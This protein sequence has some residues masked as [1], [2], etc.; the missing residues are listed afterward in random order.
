MKYILILLVPLMLMAC[1]GY[2]KEI[3]FEELGESSTYGNSDSISGDAATIQFTPYS[4][5]VGDAY[6]D[7]VAQIQTCGQRLGLG[8]ANI[9]AAAALLIPNT[10]SIISIAYQYLGGDLNL[11]DELF[12]ATSFD[13][14][15]SILAGVSLSCGGTCNQE[16]GDGVKTLAGEIASLGI[17][18][19]ELCL[20]S[21][22]V[23]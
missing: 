8:L 6:D 12:L 10:S 1:G 23:R 21:V 11:K 9:S 14:F 19:Q 13:N 18:G 4:Y 22:K 5:D 16:N 15:P 3:T 17:G 2:D 7:G 20:A